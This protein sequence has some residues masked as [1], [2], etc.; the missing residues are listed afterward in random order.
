MRE[1]IHMYTRWVRL[2]EEE[3]LTLPKHMISPQV[4]SRVRIAQYLV[5]CVNV[6]PFVLFHFGHCIV[7]LSAI[8]GF[9][10][11][12][13]YFQTFLAFQ[14][15][16]VRLLRNQHL[17]WIF[18]MLAHLTKVQGYTHYLDSDTTSFCS[19]SLM[20]RV[21]SGEA[22]YANFMEWFD[23]FQKPRHMALEACTL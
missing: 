14:C 17:S 18:M 4:F 2:V 19:Y 13:W 3:L 21:L 7:C 11:L 1:I 10:F 5:F 20:L 16:N 8:Y 23:R 9:W 15:D 22:A 12:L 6:C